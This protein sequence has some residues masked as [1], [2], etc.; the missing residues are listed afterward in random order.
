MEKLTKIHL[1]VKSYKIAHF[2]ISTE[3]YKQLKLKIDARDSGTLS[4]PFDSYE[5][6]WFVFLKQN[7][8]T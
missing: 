2:I 4:S 1:L 7:L 8:V 5:P 6:N 3:L